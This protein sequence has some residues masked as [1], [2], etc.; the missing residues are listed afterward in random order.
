LPKT[1]I[2]TVSRLLIFPMRRSLLG[3]SAIKHSLSPRFDLGA[4][5]RSATGGLRLQDAWQFDADVRAIA[6]NHYVIN[7][8][9]Q[10]YGR[11][12][13]PFQSLTFPVGTQQHFHS[14]AVHFSSIPERFMCGV[15]VALEDIDLEAGPLVY[16]PGSHKWPIYTNEHIGA[17][18]FA[19]GEPLS[20][21]VVG[22]ACRGE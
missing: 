16:Y 10:T 20:Q 8:L 21:Q 9:S 22:G 7:L 4:W 6:C 13:W 17:N 15:W 11:Q 19:G 2:A 3:P 1:S 12:A 18:T 14:D 5:R